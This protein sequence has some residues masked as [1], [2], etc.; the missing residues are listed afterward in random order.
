MIDKSKPVTTGTLLRISPS[1][2]SVLWN[3]DYTA[4]DGKLRST[5]T[6][7]AHV[8]I[9]LHNITGDPSPRHYWTDPFNPVKIT[10]Q[11][12]RNMGLFYD[13]VEVVHD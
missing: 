10:I 3:V 12:P 9:L 6:L 7:R 11:S 2:S 5:K 1:S 4:E 13:V 8:I